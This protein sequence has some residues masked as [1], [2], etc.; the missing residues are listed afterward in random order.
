MHAYCR[1]ACQRV[2]VIRKKEAAKLKH[3]LIN[4]DLNINPV[5][6]ISSQEEMGLRGAEV[7]AKRVKPNFAIIFEGS[8]ADD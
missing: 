8:P 3:T 1:Y 4:K 7:A 2:C 6:I 5:G